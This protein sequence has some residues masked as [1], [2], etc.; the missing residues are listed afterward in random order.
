MAMQAQKA[1]TVAYRRGTHLEQP[2]FRISASE[3]VGIVN[4]ST[5]REFVWLLRF[6]ATWSSH[7]T[8]YNAPV[9][10]NPEQGQRPLRPKLE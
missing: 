2:E 5:W 4:H 9:G 10:P 1:L 6:L 3:S 8:G 7:T